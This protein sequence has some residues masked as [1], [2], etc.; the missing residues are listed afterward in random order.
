MHF[1]S[2]PMSALLLSFAF[3]PCAWG[4]EAAKPAPTPEENFKSVDADADGFITAAELV[5]DIRKKIG[6]DKELT[7]D[8]SAQIEQ[9][10]KAIIANT[11]TSGDGRVSLKEMKESGK[12]KAQPKK[13]APSDE[14][15]GVA[16]VFKKIDADHD[17]FITPKEW[18]ASIGGRMF[19][20]VA[21]LSAGQQA[22][23]EKAGKELFEGADADKDGRLTLEE[24]LHSGDKPEE[25]QAKPKAEPKENAKSDGTTAGGEPDFAAM[26]QNGDGQVTVDETAAWGK[27]RLGAGA[28]EQ[29][30][31]MVRMVGQMMID[32]ADADKDGKI[33]KAEWD[34]THEPKEKTLE[35]KAAEKFKAMDRN[36]DGALTRADLV[37]V[38]AGGNDKP[39]AE[40][41]A[42]FKDQAR[43]YIKQTDGDGDGKISLKEYTA[44]VKKQ[45][46]EEAEQAKEAAAKEAADAKAAAAPESKDNAKTADAPAAPAKDE[47]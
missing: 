5:A 44:A 28:T 26:D 14:K 25:P 47:K 38:L 45:A 31:A 1:P 41:K 8:Q 12:K 20:G 9:M 43:D 34:A 32:E 19:P 10:A 3:V 23:I 24:V 11:D 15:G 39:T 21:K 29:Q 22:E 7:A 2:V 33:S 46:E 16:E 35:E 18:Y 30:L 40:E 42:E 27:K 37:A 17:G 6:S 13:D 4:A 36:A